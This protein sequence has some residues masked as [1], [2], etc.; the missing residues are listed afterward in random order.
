MG[1]ATNP[2]PTNMSS[3]PSVECN[4]QEWGGSRKGPGKQ[5]TSQD[6]SRAILCAVDV[7]CDRSGKVADADVERHADRA[8]VLSC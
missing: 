4:E 7:T 6:I 3:M 2:M 5:R 8:L 1:S